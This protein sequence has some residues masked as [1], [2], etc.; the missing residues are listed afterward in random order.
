MENEGRGVGDVCIKLLRLLLR[1]VEFENGFCIF[2]KIEL[3]LL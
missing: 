2:S 3:K 1:R